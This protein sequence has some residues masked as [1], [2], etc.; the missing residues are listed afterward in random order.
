MKFHES[1]F[2]VL[3]NQD[4]VLL[5]NQTC[6]TWHLCWQ[7]QNT[8]KC[9]NDGNSGNNGQQ[10]PEV[11]TV[12]LC[13]IGECFWQLQSVSLLLLFPQTDWDMM[14]Q[15]AN[16]PAL[17]SV[18][19]CVQGCGWMIRAYYVCSAQILCTHTDQLYC[20]RRG[21]MGSH[22][23]PALLQLWLVKC[24]CESERGR[25]ISFVLCSILWAS[26]TPR[27]ARR[28]SDVCLCV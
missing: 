5:H 27:T 3:H 18:C 10:R 9:P 28:C 26:N 7:T 14:Q 25:L 6:L 12:S 17:Y 23:Q 20:S 11:I 1:W 15:N 2:T 16:Y 8:G 4:Y 24:V 13:W 19:V 22:K 21:E